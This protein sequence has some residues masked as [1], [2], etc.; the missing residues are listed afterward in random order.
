MHV[1]LEGEGRDMVGCIQVCLLARVDCFHQMIIR[2]S[3]FAIL[4]SGFLDIDKKL[5]LATYYHVV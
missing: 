2:E 1:E 3:W 5:L 4:C